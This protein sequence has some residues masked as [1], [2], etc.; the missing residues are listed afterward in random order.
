[1]LIIDLKTVYLMFVLASL[2]YAIGLI[3]SWFGDRAERSLLLFSLGPLFS[4]V[5]GAMIGHQKTMPLWLALGGGNLMICASYQAMIAGLALY[6]GKR[7]P[8]SILAAFNTA[9]FLF[10][11]L[12]S[13]PEWFTLRVAVSGIAGGLLH[14]GI[15]WQFI[16]LKEAGSRI[17]ALCG[18]I[19]AMCGALGN[20]WRAMTPVPQGIHSAL[21]LGQPFAWN[22]VIIFFLDCLLLFVVLHLY[23]I[24]L[25]GKLTYLA[26][27]DVLTSLLNRRRFQEEVARLRLNGSSDSHAVLMIDI[28][29]FKRINDTYGHISGD[30][31]LKHF[32]A[33]L[34]KKLRQ[35]DIAARF[36][37][38]EFV[39]LLRDTDTELAYVIA[40]RLRQDV[41]ATGFS[42]GEKSLSYTISIGIAGFRPLRGEGHLEA[43]DLADRALYTAKRGGRN[44]S[45]V[46]GP[47]AELAAIA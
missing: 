1:M 40:E 39:V 33:T 42:H 31:V 43:I 38:E 8:W 30:A 21:D 15:A 36:G 44:R 24:R 12:Y 4:G 19:T 16:H 41:E 34:R 29:H 46:H 9:Y 25:R 6:A 32:A 3:V 26:S 13:E 10:Y 37:G 23:H 22:L 47:G 14:L 5:G 28:D 7:P 45:V 20:A 35:H 18:A 27:F 11:C 2:V 17:T